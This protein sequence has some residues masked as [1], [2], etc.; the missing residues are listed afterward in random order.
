ML[1]DNKFKSMSFKGGL[2]AATCTTFLLIVSQFVDLPFLF[3]NWELKSK[4]ILELNLKD[5]FYPP[6]AAIAL[7]PFLWA[8]PTFATGIFFYYFLS[9]LVYYKICVSVCEAKIQKIALIALPAN[10]YLSWL[11]LTS[12]DQV[13]ELLFLLLFILNAIRGNFYFAILAGWLLCLTRP[14]Y[15]L[16]FI[17]IVFIYSYFYQKRRSILMAC[18]GLF[19]LFLTTLGNNMIF[20]SPNL[21][22]SSGITFYY[23][24]NKYFYLSLPK[25]DMDVFLKEHMNSHDFLQDKSDFLFI[26]DKNFRAGLVSIKENPKE[27]TIASVQKINSYFFSIE[28]VPNLSG[29]YFLSG[30]GTSIIIG[31][32]R[33][34]WSIIF[35]NF[36]YSIYKFIWILLFGIL[37]TYI[38]RKIITENK[39]DNIEVFIPLPYI[40]GVIPGILFYSETRFKICAELL[41]V[42]LLVRFLGKLIDKNS[43]N[44]L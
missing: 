23:S 13:I 43:S 18:S 22:T 40:M 27:F 20:S 3:G 24:H 11:C 30:D 33:K 8:G 9:A 1:I 17:L 32:E 25:F 28:K 38:I 6:A 10:S 14:Q 2:Y 7:I 31:Q 5:N 15:W 12:A 41:L 35:G 4:S 34:S 26:E 44:H 16:V 36:F 21:A 37:L 29:E 19:L 39:L 42:P